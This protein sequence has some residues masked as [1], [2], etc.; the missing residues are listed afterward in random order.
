MPG[1]IR[2]SFGDGQTAR[3]RASVKRRFAEA[4]ARRRVVV[5]ARD[6]CGNDSY[7]ARTVRPRAA[8]A[9]RGLT[10]PA[11]RRGGVA[12]SP[13]PGGWCGRR[14]C[15]RR[16]GGVTARPPPPTSTAPPP[17]RGRRGSARRCARTAVAAPRAVG[18]RPRV[19]LRG[20]RPGLYRLEVS[21]AERGTSLGRLPII[22]PDRVGTR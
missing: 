18:F 11:R 15:A 5:T 14:R 2:W 6:A 8:S 9:V 7:A 21:A 20:L 3:G 10:V 1:S 22:P 16:S 4:R 13:S 19:P 12:A 17:L